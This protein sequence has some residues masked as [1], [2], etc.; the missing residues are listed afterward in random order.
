MRTFPVYCETGFE[1]GFIVSIHS[2]NNS[3]ERHSLQIEERAK[4]LVPFDKILFERKPL[5]S[6]SYQN[7]SLKL[8]VN[9]CGHSLCSS[10]VNLLFVHGQA[11]CP[12]VTMKYENAIHNYLLVFEK[13]KKKWFRGTDVR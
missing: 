11:P 1:R 2:N 8:M 9:D 7:P 12:Q 10:C 4:P 5:K 13:S 6:R 3:K